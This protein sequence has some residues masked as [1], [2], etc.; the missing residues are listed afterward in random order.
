MNFPR[1]NRVDVMLL[2][3]GTFPFVS[4]GV[5][6]WVNQMIRSFPEYRFGGVFLGS[7][8]EEYSGLKYELPD[9][10]VHFEAHFLY[11]DDEKPPVNATKGNRE[12]FETIRDL[13]AWLRYPDAGKDIGDK[14]WDLDFYLSSEKGVDFSQFLY[15]QRAWEFVTSMY[16]ERCTDPSFVDYFWTVRSMHG[17]IW[18]LAAIARSLIPAGIFHTV[19]TGYAGFLGALL[20]RVQQRPL[21]LSE[22]GIYTKERRI[23]IFQSD[24]IRDNRNALQKDP[25]EISYYRDLWIRFY[26]SLGRICYDSS[27]HIVSLFEG[28][29]Q[30]EIADGASAEKTSVIPNG[31]NIERFSPVRLLQGDQP[32][33]VLSLIGRIVS[34][35]DIKNFIRSIRILANR[36]PSIVGWIVGPNDEDPEYADECRALAESLEIGDRVIFK[37]FMDVTDALAGTGV[38]VL[39]SISEGLPLA[40]LEAFAAGVPVVAT[41]VGACRLLVT[42]GFG[43]EDIAIGP[44]GAVVAINNPQALADSCLD[45]LQSPEKWRAARQAAISRV[46]RYYSQERMVAAYRELYVGGL[47]HGR[48]RV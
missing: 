11:G 17:P 35:K 42:G 20:S 23:D 18:Q 14:L 15:S 13:H 26:E 4:G 32:P 24:W 5:S 25:T 40:I 6:S 43:E 9:N 28:A 12:G 47:A 10:L 38:L 37:G 29:R 3:E 7:R 21:I 31:I 46:E 45:L 19:S 36:I 2:L 33:M 41:D 48:D 30:R 22:H 44:A 27:H 39:S 1:G 8:P 34:I 16:Q